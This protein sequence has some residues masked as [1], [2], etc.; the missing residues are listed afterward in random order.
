MRRIHPFWGA[1]AALVFDAALV[2]CLLGSVGAML[3]VRTP[4]DP[5]ETVTGFFEALKAGNTADA[6]AL[7]ENYA[8]LGLENEPATE[9][10]QLLLNALLESYEYTLVGECRKKGLR[11]EQTVLLTAL[12]LNKVEEGRGQDTKI[13]VARVLEE[14]PD[15]K[16]TAEYS[17]KL[18]YTDEGWR[19]ELDE[20]LVNALSGGR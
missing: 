10:G 2:L 14:D 20:A 7:L 5:R 12:D 19:I 6:Y 18:R 8:S 17:V 11:A 1:L 3:C 13:P 15:I 9:D 4:G 16:T